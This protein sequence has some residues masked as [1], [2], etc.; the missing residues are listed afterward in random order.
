MLSS[1]MLLK[2]ILLLSGF[3]GEGIQQP[4]YPQLPNI[5]QFQQ[6]MLGMQQDPMHHQVWELLVSEFFL[7]V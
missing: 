5:D 6:R 2:I 7:V 1:K 3:P 4:V